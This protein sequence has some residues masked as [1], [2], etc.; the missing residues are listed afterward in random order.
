[1][2][3]DATTI[4]R[5]LDFELGLLDA[6]ADETIAADWGRSFLTPSLPLVWD[7]SCL[8]LEAPGLT[9]A[10]VAALADEALGGAGV[11]HRAVIVRDPDEGVRLAAEIGEAEGWEAE[12]NE[13]MVWTGESGREPAAA[14]REARIADIGALRAELND[15]ALYATAPQREATVAQ[16]LERDRRLGAA[17]GDRWFAAPAE[18]PAAACCLFGDGT[19]GQVES[20]VTLERARGRGL[21]QAVTL[22]AARASQDAGHELTFIVADAEDWPRLLYAKLGFRTIGSVNILRRV[23]T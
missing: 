7:A 20:V 13:Y 17:G 21:A 9:M 2:A 12:R 16:L 22:A 8:V 5:L 4:R 11:A 1:M 23:P 3:A 6:I 14:V 15:N 19:I 10:A 18:A